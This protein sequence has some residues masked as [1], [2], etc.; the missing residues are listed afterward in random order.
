LDD[1]PLIRLPRALVPIPLDHVKRI[2]LHAFCDASERAYGAVPAGGTLVWTRVGEV[3][4][5]EDQGCP[6]ETPEPPAVGAYG[7]SDCRP[8]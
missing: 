1:L 8:T 6:S 3:S 2:E 4:C 5:G 7:R